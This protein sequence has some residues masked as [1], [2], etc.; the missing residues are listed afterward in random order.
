MRVEEVMTKDVITI[1]V[2]SNLEDVIRI[3]SDNKI[4][5]APVIKDDK[6]VGIISES[7]ILKRLGIQNLLSITNQK[8]LEK[9]REKLSKLSVGKV[10]KKKVYTIQKDLNIAEAAKIMNDL[11]INRLP[12]VSSEG[13]IVGLITRGDLIR[14][15]ANSLGSLLFLEKKEPI[16]LETDVDRILK[17][18]EEKESVTVEDLAKLLNAKKEKVEEWGEILEEHGLIKIE[19]LATGKTIFKKI[20]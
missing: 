13:K 19:Y 7:D 12:V 5:G 6:I 10:M 3:F 2:D 1:S 14:A 20:E 16:V 11:D 4:S 8:E 18:I 15:L 17:I 9:I